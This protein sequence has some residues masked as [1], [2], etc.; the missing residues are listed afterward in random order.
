[1]KAKK[2][3]KIS[4][5]SGLINAIDWD[6][7]GNVTGVAIR[8][9]EEEEYLVMGDDIGKELLEIENEEVKAKGVV[10]EDQDGNRVITISDYEVIVPEPMEEETEDSYFA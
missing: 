8:T 1:M 6:E 2:K 9:A 3:G 7:D 10:T 5:V 4:T